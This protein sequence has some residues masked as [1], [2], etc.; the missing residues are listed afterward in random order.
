MDADTTTPQ[1]HDA[2]EALKKHFG[3]RAFLDG[4]EDVIANVLAGRDALVVMPTGGGKSLCY[5]LPALVMDGVTLVVSPL[6]AL[7]KDQVDALVNRGISATLINSTLTL[8]EQ[9]ER[10]A[11]MRGGAY[12]LVYV[13]PERF[14]SG[15]F[16]DALRQVEIA[17]FAVDEAHCLSQWG[18]DFRPDYLRLGHALEKL[19][20]PQVLA[21]TATATSDVRGDIVQHLRLRDPFLSVRGFSRPN[22]SL[23]ITHTEKS[24]HKYERLR[25]IIA[26]WKT[27]IIYCA[28]RKRVEE[29]TED[30]AESKVKAIA[31]HGGLDE[32]ERNFAQDKF[33]Q[34]KANIVVATNAFGMGID[35][36]DVRFVAHF[37]VPGSIE[38]YYQEAGRAGRDGEPS[39][40]ELFFN[41]A[42]T[43]TQEFFIEGA[44]PTFETI[45]DIFQTLLNWADNQHAVHASIEDIADHAGVKNSMS[46]SSAL[47]LLARQGVIERFDIPGKRVRGTRLVKPDMLARDLNLDR[48]ALEE[49]ERRDRAKLKAMIE[50]C[51]ADRCRQ[52]VILE[53]FGE[54]DASPCGNCDAC[55]RGGAKATARLGAAEEIETL[56]KALSGVARMC[57]RDAEGGWTPRFGKGRIIAMLLGSKSQEVVNAGLD[58]LTTY[59]LLKKVGSAGV[60]Q[61]FK[62]ME[63]LQYIETVTEDNFPLLRITSEGARVMRHGGAIKMLWPDLRGTPSMTK[64]DTK[65]SVAEDEDVAV[66]ELGFD[67]KLF[68]KLKKKR[69]EISQREGV[70]PFMVFHNN[71]LEFFTRLRPK[72]PEAGKKIR[73]VGEAKAQKWLADFIAVIVAHH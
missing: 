44:N 21:L 11:G 62:E 48:D 37:D 22:L 3:F 27:G 31:Y 57:H 67:E 2:R 24:R 13:A 46:V 29:V 58:E 4:Q 42:D 52:Q 39:H 47:S 1:V 59:G 14:R 41:F 66:T 40:C 32:K 64:R 50:L 43:R 17:L 72:T 19:D 8:D 10:I 12:K 61:L 28:T 30:L 36:S 9:K 18:H 20:R 73:G 15:L 33:L 60:H 35:R 34:R 53:Y 23:N 49:K 65:S 69:L 54:E 71:T 63:R 70:P 5:Q 45:R 26:Q 68:E 25:E 38:A 16:L 55:R 51:Y 7:M 56:R 6:I